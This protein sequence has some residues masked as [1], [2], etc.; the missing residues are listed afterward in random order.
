MRRFLPYVWIVLGIAVVAG[1]AL[2]FHRRKTAQV[3]TKTETIKVERQ[4]LVVSVTAVGVL[5]PLTTVDVKANVAGE[6]VEL[7]VDRGDRV[8]RGDLIARIDPTETQAAYDQ[9]V[10]DVT[11]AQARIREAQAEL[12]RQSRLQPA[13]VTAAGEGVKTARARVNQA[14]A[15]LDHQAVV[16]QTTIKQRQEAIK[17]AEARVRQAE[18]KANSQPTISETTVRQAQAQ[19]DAAQQG[20][21]KLRRASH[22]QE[23]ASA[24]SNIQASKVNL[25]NQTKALQRLRTLNTRGGVSLQ[26]VENAE[27]TTADAQDRYTQ[28][29]AALDS[30]SE[31]QAAE[32]SEAQAVIEQAQ[33]ALDKANAGRSDVVVAREE[34]AAARAS[35]KEAE[36]ALEAAVAGKAQDAMKVEDL[37]AAEAGVGEARAQTQVARANA[38]QIR[39]SAQQVA[40]ARAAA[41]KS[42][43]ALDNARKNLA[44]TTVVAPRDG[45]VID[46]FVEEGTVVTSGRSSVAQGINIVTLADESRMFV[47]AEVDEADIGQVK[48]GQD[49]EIEI[50]TFRDRK[51]KGR[52]MEVYPKGEEIDNVTI[53]RVRVEVLQQDPALRTGMTAEVNIIIARKD[54]VLVVPTD[55]IFEQD[56]QTVVEV[57]KGEGTEQ[58]RVDKGLSNF[59]W[60]EVGPPLKEGDEIVPGTGGGGSPFGGKN[61]S[62]RT[63][64]KMMKMGGGKR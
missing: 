35:L 7:A 60:T 46:R 64:Q 33:A 17:T 51:F 34:L 49:A 63:M 52:V 16:T 39:A 12:D 58:I 5:E 56:G 29:Q 25:D 43:A 14:A 2:F 21:G 45:V 42:E 4:D 47:L 18:A 38:A 61:D 44:Y 19:M 50:E 57:P 11:S 48:V 54:G 37:R 9:A 30:L 31:R 40:Q 23:R 8:M 55:A 32:I 20:L 28:A 24:Q 53:F 22:P 36:A 6:I 13:Q 10:A 27:R 59:E 62:K 3:G 1:L 26:E 15:S 41:R